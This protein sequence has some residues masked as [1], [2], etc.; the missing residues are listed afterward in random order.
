MIILPG[1]EYYCSDDNDEF[2]KII[3]VKEEGENEGRNTEKKKRG[4]NGYWMRSNAWSILTELNFRFL[5]SDWIGYSHN[6]ERLMVLSGG[7]RKW[8][9]QHTLG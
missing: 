1:L 9:R 3:L 8:E 4:G 6:T 2:L 5:L 7:G